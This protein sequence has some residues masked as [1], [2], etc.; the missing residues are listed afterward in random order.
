VLLRHRV[1]PTDGWDMKPGWKTTEFWLSTAVSAWAI[2][3][4]VL[5]PV[6]QAVVVGVASGAYSI[7]RAVAKAAGKTLP[8]A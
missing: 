5:P 8:A 3:G 4:H 7:A 1:R 2:F 6:A